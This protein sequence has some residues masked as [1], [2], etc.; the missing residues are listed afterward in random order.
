MNVPGH[1]TCRATGGLS[2]FRFDRRTPRPDGA[3]IDVLHCGICH[4][5]DTFG[6]GCPA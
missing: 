2:P 5:G 6:V 4:A 3:A 1:T